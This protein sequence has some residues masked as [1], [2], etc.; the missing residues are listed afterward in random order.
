M[1]TVSYGSRGTDVE[2]LQLALSH[3]GWYTGG[4]DGTFGIGTQN[5]VRR[6]QAE[7]E[8]RPDGIVGL[9]TWDALDP[10]LT[11][12]FTATV[13]RG[14]TFYKLARR[15][16]TTAAAIAAA[17]PEQDPQ[18]LQIGQKLVIPFGFDLVPTNVRYTSTLTDYILDGLAVRYPFAKPQKYGHS[19]SGTPLRLISFGT[20]ERGVL[21]NASHHAN[22]WI[23]TPLVLKFAET[24][25]K[26]YISGNTVLGRS[27]RDLL[28]RATVYIAPLVNPDGV[29]L[30][31]GALD[32]DS[33]EYAAARRIAANYPQVPFPSGWKANIEG[34]DLNLNY[35]AGWDEARRIKFAEGWT[36]PAP[37]DFVGTSPLAA[38]E[39]RA[40]YDLTLDND[41]VLSISYHTQG[42]VIYWN[43]KD[44][45]PRRGL[46]IANAMAEAS[47]Y[48]VED[49]PEESANA[50]YK[51]WFILNYDLPGYTIEAGKGVNPLPLSQFD[52]IFENNLPLLVT[53]LELS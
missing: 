30:V 6:F 45:D 12:H 24:L 32:P 14:D 49:V 25:L 39:S 15:Y 7:H 28:A 42:E 36:S 23:T 19:V 40:L 17:N 50:G 37:R 4:I 2:L 43:Y 26:A 34:T 21:I 13:R 29:E 44:I 35:P 10:F 41:F 48:S 33:S 46:E 53:A 1:K 52:R 11:G 38:P 18:K 51:D 16:A 47:G 5:A 27:A 9:H 20:G 3:G 22:E 8:L 31:T